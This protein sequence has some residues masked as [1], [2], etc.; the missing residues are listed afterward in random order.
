MADAL[1]A[2]DTTFL[3]LERSTRACSAMAATRHTQNKSEEEVTDVQ[4][5]GMGH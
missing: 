3:E 2:I 5:S 1:T 4:E